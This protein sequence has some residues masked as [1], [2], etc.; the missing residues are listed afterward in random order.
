M[1]ATAI[2]ARVD[3]YS[4]HQVPEGDEDMQLTP[5]KQLFKFNDP[6]TALEF[7]SDGNLLLAGESTGRV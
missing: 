3:I 1:L 6:V 2:S 7:R 5:M 4:L